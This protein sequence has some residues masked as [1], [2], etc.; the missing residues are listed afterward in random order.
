MLSEHNEPQQPAGRQAEQGFGILKTEPVDADTSPLPFID[1][2]LIAADV[3]LRT[4][5]GASHAS[6]P[7]PVPAID[8]SEALTD[9]QRRLSGALDRKSVV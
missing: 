5:S 7:L 6:R 3:A 4:L 8:S 1:S 2:M 9:A